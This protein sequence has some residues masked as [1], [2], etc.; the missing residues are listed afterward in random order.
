MGRSGHV[1]SIKLISLKIHQGDFP[2]IPVAKTPCFQYIRPGFEPWLGNYFPHATIK[3]SKATT[4][5]PV[6]HHQDPTQINKYFKNTPGMCSNSHLSALDV[7]ISKDF[8]GN[9]TQKEGEL[10]GAG[11]QRGKI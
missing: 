8:N 5:D 11:K 7:L 1:Y 9:R 10:S 2:G 4:K 6:C 3:S